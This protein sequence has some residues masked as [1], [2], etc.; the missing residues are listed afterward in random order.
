MSSEDPIHFGSDLMVG[1]LQLLL[2]DFHQNF[3]GDLLQLTTLDLLASQYNLEEK[4][5]PT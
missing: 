5:A 3:S 4:L 2:Q 1:T